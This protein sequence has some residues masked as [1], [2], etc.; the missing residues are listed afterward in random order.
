MPLGNPAFAAMNVQGF[1]A[2]AV[3]SIGYVAIGRSYPE[4][5]RPRMFAVLSSAWVIPGL[6]GPSL[7][8]IVEHALGWRWVFLGL[9]PF[10]LVAG[11]MTLPALGQI[12]PGGHD[13]DAS[14]LPLA[15]RVA[16][17]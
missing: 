14:R 1:G 2:G 5:L 15:L 10:V 13:D 6:L 3:P 17:A 12:G 9:L 16:V 11:V 7:A 8:S 4:A